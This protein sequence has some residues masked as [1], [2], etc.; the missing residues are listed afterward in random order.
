MKCLR[1]FGG[2]PYTYVGTYWD[3][4]VVRLCLRA[5]RDAGYLMRQTKV[6]EGPPLHM[7]KD[8][9]DVFARKTPQ[10]TAPLR[11]PVVVWA[12]LSQRGEFDHT[13]VPGQVIAWTEVQV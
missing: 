5:G 9:Y 3:R 13:S 4:E 6:T 10:A 12:S 8:G 7:G 2:K 11:I 1:K